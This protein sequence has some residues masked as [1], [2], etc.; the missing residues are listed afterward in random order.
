MRLRPEK[1]NGKIVHPPHLN[2]QSAAGNPKLIAST[3]LWLKNSSPYPQER[4]EI[5]LPF[6]FEE[7]LAYGI[8]I[9]VKGSSR[10]FRGRAYDGVPTIANVVGDAHYLVTIGLARTRSLLPDIVGLSTITN[11]KLYPQ[12]IPVRNWEDIL[13][14]VAAHEAR[15]IWQFKTRRKNGK[16]PISEVD[17]E[18]FAIEKLNA[19]RLKNKMGINE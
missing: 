17:A 6:A 9:H 15:H 13:I 11:R 8:E 1:S 10:L 18:K 2:G 16:Q 3:S 7:V 14:Y 12:G 19:W 4:L 5:L